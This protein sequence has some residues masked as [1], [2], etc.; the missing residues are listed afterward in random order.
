MKKAKYISMKVEKRFM[1][2][3]YIS[4]YM[5]LLNL[6]A[7]GKYQLNTVYQLAHIENTYTQLIA[8]YFSD[9]PYK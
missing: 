7:P 9:N 2:K 5:H 8:V 1:Q 6:I 3:A 4:R